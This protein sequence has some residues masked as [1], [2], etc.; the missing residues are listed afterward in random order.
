[1]ANDNDVV[2]YISK[3]DNQIKTI[4]EKIQVSE[5]NNMYQ[6]VKNEKINSFDTKFDTL[7]I[8]DGKRFKRKSKSGKTI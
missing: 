7:G 5:T 3:T 8:R 4:D 6:Q 2:G 1:M